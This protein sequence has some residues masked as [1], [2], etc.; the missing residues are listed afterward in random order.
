MSE[1][2]SLGE[3]PQ[4]QSDKVALLRQLHIARDPV[5][6]DAREL[7]QEHDEPPTAPSRAWLIVSA[8]LM[9]LAVAAGGYLWTQRSSKVEVQVATVVAAGPGQPGSGASLLDASGYVVARRQ[10]TV[11]S[12]VTGKVLEVLVEEGQH[13]E[14]GAVMA[15][16]DDASDRT[17][18]AQARAKLAQSLANL[19][20]ARQNYADALPTFERSRKQFQRGLISAQSYENAQATF[21]MT[22][23]N[24]PVAEEGVTLARAV[25]DSAKEALQDTI[26]K[27][28]FS[29][30]VTVKAAQPGEIVSPISAGGGFTRTGIG[31]IVDMDSLE[32]ETDVSE[33]FISRVVAGQAVTVVLNAYPDWRIPADVIAVIPTADRSKATVKVRIGLKVHDGRI[34]PDMGAR[35]SFLQPEGAAPATLSSSNDVSVPNAAVQE[36]DQTAIVFVVRPDRTLEQRAVGLARRSGEAQIIATGLRAGERVALGDPAELREGA[37]VRILT[38]AEPE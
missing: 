12:K 35:V 28:P 27:A 26:V 18:V 32:V 13:V 31:T 4:K 37:R 5:V 15:R 17:N 23:N 3:S 19:Q 33:S 21:N 38:A 36:R 9:M 24:V 10:A 1:P 8:V 22:L 30:V 14:A 7:Q 2:A 11:S 34:L 25:V 20:A 16:L 6:A 29:G